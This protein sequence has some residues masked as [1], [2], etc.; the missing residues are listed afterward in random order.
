MSFPLQGYFDQIHG[1]NE[2]RMWLDHFV[3]PQYPKTQPS[4]TAV[5]SQLIFFLTPRFS[6]RKRIVIPGTGI[7]DRLGEQFQCRDRGGHRA[8]HRGNGLL[9]HQGIGGAVIREA[10]IRRPKRV[11]ST[12][13]TRD[14]ERPTTTRYETSFSTV[15]RNITRLCQC[16]LPRDYLSWQGGH[17]PPRR[18]RRG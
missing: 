16:P 6:D 4:S 10:F 11:Q 5:L 13:R 1:S 15:N 3:I 14:A 18:S 2:W 8:K 12:E 7:Y 17:L 9:T